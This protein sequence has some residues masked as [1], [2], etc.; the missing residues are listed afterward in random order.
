VTDQ[1]ERENLLKE[2]QAEEAESFVW[3]E[4]GTSA[5]EALDLVVDSLDEMAGALEDLSRRSRAIKAAGEASPANAAM[6]SPVGARPQR[7][8]RERLQ[9]GTPL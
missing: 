2:A 5:A 8:G 3:D 1:A 4:D 7:G 9:L 6:A